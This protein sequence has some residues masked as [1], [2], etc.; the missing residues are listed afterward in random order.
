MNL[1]S[2]PYRFHSPSF[3]LLWYINEHTYRGKVLFANTEAKFVFVFYIVQPRHEPRGYIQNIVKPPISTLQYPFG[4]QI[5]S[6]LFVC[7]QNFKTLR[8]TMPSTVPKTVGPSPH[9]HHNMPC[10]HLKRD[11]SV[12]VVIHP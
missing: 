3:S 9:P 6:T 5:L 1:A 8:V 2:P 7:D 11:S 4:I 12:L 10:R